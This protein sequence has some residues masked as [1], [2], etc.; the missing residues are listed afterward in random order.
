MLLRMVSRR[1]VLGAVAAAPIVAG[2][3]GCSS[4]ASAGLDKIAYLTSYGTTPR[5]TFPCVGVAKG[6]FR[7]VGIDLTVLPGQPADANLTSLAAGKAQFAALDYV[8]AVRGAQTLFPAYAKAAGFDPATVSMVYAPPDRVVTLLGSGRVDAIGG[9]G[10]DIPNVENA[11]P[12]RTGM[13]LF[14]NDYLKDLYGT[15]VIGTTKV[16]RGQPKLTKASTTSISVHPL[17]ISR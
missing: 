11:E 1:R 9:Y 3:G 5:E 12:G 10:T 14:W 4:A 16:I 2:A 17:W 7:D 8:S 6:F 13:A 15:V